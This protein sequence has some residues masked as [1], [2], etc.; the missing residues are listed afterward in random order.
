MSKIRRGDCEVVFASGGEQHD[1][2]IETFRAPDFVEAA[3]AAA[4]F[5]VETARCM[6]GHVRDVAVRVAFRQEIGVL[7]SR[8]RTPVGIAACETRALRV[9]SQAAAQALVKTF[10]EAECLR[11]RGRDFACDREAGDGD[12]GLSRA[13]WRATRG[14]EQCVA[15]ACILD[16]SRAGREAP[17]VLFPIR[18]VELKRGEKRLG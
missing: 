5:V 8:E 3:E 12:G 7:V 11:D 4:G 2:E 15:G 9:L 17:A 6:H 14:Y 13:R 1:A 10:P 16:P 18:R